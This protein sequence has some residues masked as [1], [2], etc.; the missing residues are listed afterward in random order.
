MATVTPPT[1]G[2]ACHGD[3]CPYAR[4]YYDKLPR[5]LAAAVERAALTRQD[6][7]SLARQ[8]EVCPYEL[9]SDLLPWVDLVIADLD[10]NGTLDIA[11]ANFSSQNVSII[12]LK[13]RLDANADRALADVLSKVYDG[14]AAGAA[15]TAASMLCSALKVASVCALSVRRSS[16]NSGSM[17]T[18]AGITSAPSSSA[19]TRSRPVKRSLANAFPASEL[20]TSCWSLKKLHRQMVCSATYRQASRKPRRLEGEAIRDAMLAASGQLDFRR[21]GVQCRGHGYCTGARQK[22]GGGSQSR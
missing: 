15:T 22:S 21:G 7:E 9:A 16:R 13:L 3:D 11:V 4:G 2:R 6:I 14:G 18:C 10:G 8:F 17:P 20:M 5:A 1:P 19:N 12:T